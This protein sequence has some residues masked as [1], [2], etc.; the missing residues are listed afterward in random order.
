MRTFGSFYQFFDFA[1]GTIIGLK[2]SVLEFFRALC[3]HSSYDQIHL[4]IKDPEKF[5]RAKEIIEFLE[6]PL[7]QQKRIS[8]LPAEKLPTEFNTCEYE[9]FLHGDP[10]IHQLSYA[11]TFYCT[12][13]LFPISAFVHDL[14]PFDT[15]SR[16]LSVF[17]SDF[18]KFD[19]F[20]CPSKAVKEV[21]TL[22]FKRVAEFIRQKT[23]KT[24]KF[25]PR[26]VVA[27][28]GVDSE[29]FKP[30]PKEKLRNQLKLPTDRI[31]VLLESRLTPHHKMDL[32]PFLHAIKRVIETVKN[33]NLLFLI[34]GQEELTGYAE[35]LRKAG[36]LLGLDA[37][38]QV[39]DK[40]DNQLIP[41][42]FGAADIF[43]SPSDNIQETFGLTPLEAMSS[44]LP[45]VISNWNGYKESLTEGIEGFKIPTIWGK[46]DTEISQVAPVISGSLAPQFAISESV[47]I[48][49]ELY[50]E[51]LK[52]L[53]DNHNLR[54]KMGQAARQRILEKYSWK[55]V[56][57]EYEKIWS[58]SKDLQLR[59]KVKLSRKKIW[60]E[61][62][63]FFNFY[64][65]Y[66][67]KLISPKTKVKSTPPGQS[68]LETGKLLITDERIS[69]MNQVEISKK[70]LELCLNNYRAVA[71]VLKNLKPK[72]IL[73]KEMF[74]YQI[75]FM[76]KHNLLTYQD[77]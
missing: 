7:D 47:A 45:V 76:I 57:K 73:E 54:K 72:T 2:V 68:Y 53:I 74:L 69:R 27:P 46:I 19:T 32:F 24:I 18:Y 77:K 43:A 21:L 22:H 42:Y 1:E 60:L 67:T 28:L 4:Y 14:S 62:M 10:D 12:N 6:I 40:F 9:V 3:R 23:G 70:I 50:A 59:T 71:D 13:H 25:P 66:P 36:H 20:L 55:A 15:G 11:R 44:G 37:F 38:L 64:K 30:G 39:V 48:N 34:V 65:H 35:N 17:L 31:I 5:N 61:N 49:I 29:K 52:K 56:I 16:F 26:L 63:P 33:K 75:L 8:I 41:A 51:A 58:R